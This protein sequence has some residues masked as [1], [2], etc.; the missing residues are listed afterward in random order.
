[1]MYNMR[2][3]SPES[4][5]AAGI[6][7]IGVGVMGRPMAHNLLRKAGVNVTVHHRS[8]E[9][10]RDILS[11]G[12]SFAATPRE[13][14]RHADIVVLMLPDLP[15]VEEVLQGPDGLLAGITRKTLVIICSTSSASGIR[16]L[17]DRLAHSTDGKVA[18]V[19]APVSGGE[20]GAT[21]GTLS[22]MVGG[23]AEDVSLALPVLATMGN[24]VHLGPLGSGEIAKYCN[25]LIV[26]STIMALGEAAVLAERNGLDLESLFSTL[27]GGYAGSRVLETRKDRI[28]SREYGSSGIAKYMV[29]DLTLASEE[30]A[31]SG[32]VAA[33]LEVLLGL[34]TDLTRHGFG[35]QDISVTRAYVESQS[36]TNP[37]K[38]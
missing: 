15:E 21:A 38:D 32:T 19:D 13:V 3:S 27:E 22:I 6:G 30:A 23:A 36:S 12:A 7:F 8:P 17:Q 34:F 31:K 2:R 33:Q 26:A 4:I 28:V 14:A 11:A 25:Q 10:V 20:D 1:M 37:D 9:R 16:E 5:V 35:D 29:K 18:V 24:P